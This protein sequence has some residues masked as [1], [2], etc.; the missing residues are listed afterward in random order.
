MINTTHDA[1][2]RLGLVDDTPPS[3]IPLEDEVVISPPST[4]PHQIMP[5]NP[6]ILPSN[7]RQ[8]AVQQRLRGNNSARRVLHFR[9]E[10]P[11]INGERNRTHRAILRAL[12]LYLPTPRKGKLNFPGF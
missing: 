7:P 6:L 8:V 10:T 2:V 5:E 12:S 4:P 3:P 1:L 11:G 9:P